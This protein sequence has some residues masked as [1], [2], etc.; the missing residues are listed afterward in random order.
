MCS[1][2]G[3]ALGRAGK[4]QLGGPQRTICPDNLRIAVGLETDRT[5]TQGGWWQIAQHPPPYFKRSTI[6]FQID[7]FALFWPR[8]NA[9]ARPLK[10]ANVFDGMY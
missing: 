1:T 7:L 10:P 9:T 2:L 6:I 3:L 4:S 5:H 8:W